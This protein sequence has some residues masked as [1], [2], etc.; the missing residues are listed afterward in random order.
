M[1]IPLSRLIHNAEPAFKS[2]GQHKIIRLQ[3]G[4][5]LIKSGLEPHMQLQLTNMALEIG[6]DSDKGFWKTNEQGQKV[7]NQAPKAPYRGRI[8]NSLD[9]FPKFISKLCQENLIRAAQID[10][11]IKVIAHTHLILLYYQ[12]LPEAPKE[13]YIPWHQD[14]DANDGEEDYPVVSFTIGDSCNFCLCNSKPK[15]NLNNPLSNPQNLDH[16]ILFESGDVLFF[17]GPSRKIYHMVNKI[18]KN[19]APHFLP[20]K[21]AR[22]NFTFR[23]A[24]K[25]KGKEEKFSSKNFKSVYHQPK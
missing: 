3:P 11:E 8:F 2:C 1:K 25:I 23:Y 18:H 13:G 22:L 10:P 5:V 6:S 24:P 19:T 20:L 7:L 12:T 4:L 9:K 17:G 21:D 16:D 15:I 14:K